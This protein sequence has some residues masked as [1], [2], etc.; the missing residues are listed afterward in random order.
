MSKTSRSTSNIDAPSLL[1]S[2][3]APYETA[4]TGP[5]GT[6]ALRRL[7]AFTHF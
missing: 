6:V 2:Q 1:I 5:S 3:V 4:A 7:E